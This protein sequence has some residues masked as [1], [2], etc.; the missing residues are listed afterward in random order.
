MKSCTLLSLEEKNGANSQGGIK[1]RM[2]ESS[3]PSPIHNQVTHCWIKELYS[4]PHC[5]TLRVFPNIL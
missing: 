4:F 2:H 1:K 3:S 5:K